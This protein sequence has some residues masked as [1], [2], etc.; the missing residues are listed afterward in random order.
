VN[1]IFPGGYKC[2]VDATRTMAGAKRVL[3]AL[4]ALM[5]LMA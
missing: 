3:D 2:V 1:Q 5:A 4:M